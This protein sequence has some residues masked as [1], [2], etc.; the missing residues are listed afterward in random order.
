M[1]KGE[2]KRILRTVARR[3]AARGDF[4]VSLPKT[5][6]QWSRDSHALDLFHLG[7]MDRVEMVK[8]GIPAIYVETLA[9]SMGLTKEKLYQ[10]TGLARPTVDRKIRQRQRLNKDESESIIGLAR[11]VG[12][13]QSLVNESGNGKGF[14]AAKWTA[15]WLAQPLQALGGK[16]P[17]ELMDTA[18]GRSLVSR[19]IAQQQSGAYA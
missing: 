6:V 12:Q 5:D 19:L 10:T 11:L 17:A 13:V 3:A 4:K 7:V 16:R 8:L 14:D 15:S 18:D 2:A 1:E 9:N